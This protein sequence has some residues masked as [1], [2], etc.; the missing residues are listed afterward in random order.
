M[1]LLVEAIVM[2]L[3]KRKTRDYHQKH[4]TAHISI[5]QGGF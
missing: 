4:R 5:V 1:Q 2:E 3:S